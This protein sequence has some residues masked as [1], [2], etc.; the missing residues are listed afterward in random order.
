MRRVITAAGE[1]IAMS[2]VAIVA[3]LI[4]IA[5]DEAT[6]FLNFWRAIGHREP[7]S[8]WWPTLRTTDDEGEAGE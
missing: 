6:A 5:H 3:A 1:G 7:L 4:L 8:Y 2:L